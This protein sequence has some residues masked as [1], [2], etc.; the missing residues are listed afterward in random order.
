MELHKARQRILQLREDLEAH[1]YRYYV[2]AEPL[3]SDATF[4]RMMRELEMLEKAFPELDDPNS[5][6]RRVGGV[7]TKVFD[8]AAHPV[9]M[10]SL[11]NTYSPEE[12]DDFLQRVSRE[13]SGAVAFC[14]ELKYDGVAISLRYE[15][16]ILAEA[17]TRGDG[18]RGDVVTENIRTI[19][20]IPLR[21][22]GDYPRQ[23]IIRG[24]VLM[25]DLAFQSLNAS[26][27]AEGKALF[28]NPRNAAA[29]SLKLQDASEVAKRS[30]DCLLY[31]VIEEEKEFQT[32]FESLTAA[33]SWGFKVPEHIRRCER[34]EEVHAF[35]SY[36]EEARHS[37]PFDTDG[38]VIKVDSLTQQSALGNT[39]KSP[40]W[41]IAY[42]YKAEEARTPLL[43][44]DFQVGRTG[45]VTPVA[46]LQ[47]VP[48]AGTIVKRA[49]LHNAD[50]IAG[51]DL[52]QGDT[53]V[54]EKGGEII[55][56]ITSVVEALRPENAVPVRFPEFCPECATPLERA[57][58]EAAHYCPNRDACPPQIK[59]RIEHF[60][61]RR[62]MD[63]ESLGEGKVELLF[64]QGLI[65]NAADLYDLSADQLL[66]LE[67]VFSDDLNGTE[68]V[69]RFREKTVENILRGIDSSRKVPF[70][71][72]L[73]A[74]GIRY[75]GET[76]AK[77][78][79]R[80]FR[81]ME[82]LALASEEELVAVDE[83]GPRIAESVCQ[84]FE[85][86]ENLRMIARLEKHGLQMQY[87]GPEEQSGPLAGKS[88]VVSGVFIHYS[89]DEI[90]AL[91][92]QLGGKNTGSLSAKTDFLLAGENMGPAKRVKAEK[93]GIPV[94]SEEAFREMLA[95]A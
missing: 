47:A 73:F 37:L 64:D 10:L 21:L 5:P 38:V 84:F 56:K 26:R 71:R 30:L 11:S 69:M 63:I 49:S 75:V 17:L 81:S 8:S 91:I 33:R 51:L 57:D 87:D 2:L 92:E 54:V 1:N 74:L 29:G 79:A 12:V 52:H 18:Q 77:K 15:D 13:V 19:R 55:P 82:A 80:H 78:L 7:V 28:A 44:V 43:S 23:L 32:H 72:L 41:A 39:A 46:N 35:I 22:R 89:R 90:K 27:E 42:K 66:G 95:L 59:G 68:R 31:N 48:L 16:G 88:I 67:K 45:A 62:A 86:E 60:I 40:R 85:K 76:T 65:K 3:I 9:P 58:E 14:C 70:E 24:E 25:P 61:S 36:W 53:V 4:D 93:L 50:I 34:I 20:S 6:S 83:V 94:L